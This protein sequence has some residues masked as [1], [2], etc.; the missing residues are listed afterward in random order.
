MRTTPFVVVIVGW[1]S[2][3]LVQSASAQT[4]TIH[5]EA[6]APASTAGEAAPALIEDGAKFNT[7]VGVNALYSNT[8]YYNT[9][10]G[11][12]ALYSN[13]IGSFNMA[14]GTWALYYNT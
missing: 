9:A 1:A 5:T 2:L 11:A 4:V 14:S 7:A 6:S 12:E 8:G 3:G 13:D 10:S